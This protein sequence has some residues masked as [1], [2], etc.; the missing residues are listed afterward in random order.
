MHHCTRRLVRRA[1]WIYPVVMALVVMAT[2][3]HYLLDV[4]GGAACAFAGTWL[5]RAAHRRRDR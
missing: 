2:A 5:A 1:V 4:V 3:N